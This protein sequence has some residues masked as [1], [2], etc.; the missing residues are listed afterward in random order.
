MIPHIIIFRNWNRNWRII[1]FVSE[2]VSWQ[3]RGE[4]NTSRL[5]GIITSETGICLTFLSYLIV[6]ASVFLCIASHRS[7]LS[8]IV[9][10]PNKISVIIIKCCV[11]VTSSR[12]STLLLLL[13]LHKLKQVSLKNAKI[14]IHNMLAQSV[15]I[16]MYF[17]TSEKWT[18]TATATTNHNKNNMPRWWKKNIVDS[19]DATQ[20]ALHFLPQIHFALARCVLFRI[21]HTKMAAKNVCTSVFRLTYA[22][23][24]GCVCVCVDVYNYNAS[25]HNSFC[26]VI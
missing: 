3:L 26:A 14:T 4:T 24:D 19:F 25:F 6:K 22:E 18:I 8:M 15:C 7:P 23:N 13:P 16:Y 1:L 5:H 17:K 9:L 10:P 12:R 2:S 21:R 11:D 20:I